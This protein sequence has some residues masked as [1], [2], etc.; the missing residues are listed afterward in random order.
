MK[1]VLRNII[2]IVISILVVFFSIY[3]FR[4][5]SFLSK[6]DIAQEDIVGQY[7]SNGVDYL[8][9]A[10]NETGLFYQNK[11][12]HDFTYLKNDN[13]YILT[14]INDFYCEAIPVDN[15]T[16]FISHGNVLLTWVNINE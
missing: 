9:F 2:I 15:N 4:S 11:N 5:C 8:Y 6:F 7:F 13:V 10:N 14:G 1:K 3:I 12:N 16:F